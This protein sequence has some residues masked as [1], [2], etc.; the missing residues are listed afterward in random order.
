MRL[1]TDQTQKW[2]FSEIPNIEESNFNRSLERFFDLGVNG[3]TREN[4][5]NSLDGRVLDYDGPVIV[6]IKTGSINQ[7]DVPGIE[8]VK[9]RI[10]NLEGRN[11]YTKE[12]IDHMKNKLDQ[13]EVRYISFEDINTRGL[14]GAKNGQ[15]GS[16]KDTWGIYAYNKGVHFE[17][18]NNEVEISRGGSHG[19]GKI[20][21]NAASDLHVMYFANCDANGDQHLGGTVQL[22]EHEFE[23]QTYR[24]TGYFADIKHDGANNRS[25]FYPYENNFH[26]VFKK[27]TRGLRIII[28][29]FRKE[30]DDEVAIIKSV[31]DSFFISILKNKLEVH[32]NEEKIT[33]D[34]ILTYMKNEKYY[35]QEITEAKKEFT[36]LYLDTYLDASSKEI[37]VSNKEEDFHFNLYFRYDERIPKGRVAIVRTIGMKIEDFIV[38]GHATKPFNAVLI[39]GPKEDAY[40]KSLENESHT[41]LSKDHIND[42]KLKKQATRF[43]NNLSREIAKEIDEA[44]RENN[45]TDGLMETKDI[46][47]IVETQFKKD[48]EETMGT[49]RVTNGKSLVK[50]SG[51]ESKKEKRNQRK[52]KRE[53]ASGEKVTQKRKRDPLKWQKAKDKTLNDSDEGKERYSAHPEMV[54]RVILQDREMIKFD[55]TG[56]DQLGGATTCDISL[57]I[58]DGM[59]VEYDDEFNIHNSYEEILDIHT[60]NFCSYNK[61]VI[62]DVQIK[63]GIAKLQF[64]LKN[65]FNRS[66]KFVYYVEV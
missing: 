2:K 17:E 61:D 19:V 66:L 7:N 54:E 5:Q 49:V 35:N 25:K 16:R 37:V 38:Q 52:N 65:N 36:P 3:L 50:S 6:K 62:K 64:N 59:G 18:E 20:A 48:L 51:K 14:T 21:S 31:C 43:I 56:S 46:L 4:I 40:L 44:I 57:S 10:L 22:I 32:I 29:Y 12:T 33:K 24:S 28:P 47:Y 55:F 30:Y 39:G 1:Q 58:I 8:N 41:K 63:D 9:E 27:D 13:D 26:E 45:Q 15:S 42:A 53:A 60:G 11:S 34:T 23:G